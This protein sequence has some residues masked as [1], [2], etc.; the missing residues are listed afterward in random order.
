[1]TLS[2]WMLERDDI[3]YVMDEDLMANTVERG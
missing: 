3:G 1:M 2:T